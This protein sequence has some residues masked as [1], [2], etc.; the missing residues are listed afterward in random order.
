MQAIQADRY[1]DDSKI[2]KSSTWMNA[3]TNVQLKE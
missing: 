3:Q 1:I 2:R